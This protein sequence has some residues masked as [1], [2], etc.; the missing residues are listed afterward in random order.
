M[1]RLRQAAS[2]AGRDFSTLSVNM[3]APPPEKS[4]LDEYREAT[5]E[6]SF[7]LIPDV[8]RDEILGVLDKYARLIA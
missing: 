2:A 8:T 4:I 1:A 5:V 6:R 7:L 3:F